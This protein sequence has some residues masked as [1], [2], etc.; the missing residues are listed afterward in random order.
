ML[1]VDLTAVVV[2]Q[3][4][5]D[6]M[7]TRALMASWRINGHRIVYDVDF[8]D[9]YVRW[10]RAAFV[11]VVGC[12]YVSC[13]RNPALGLQQVHEHADSIPLE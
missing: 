5:L 6:Y 13:R 11:I 10:V 9:A 7:R 3:P 1:G 8:G 4:F 2:P 12:A